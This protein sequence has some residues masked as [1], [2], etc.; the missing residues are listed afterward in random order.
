[1]IK[2]IKFSVILISI[3]TIF[4]CGDDDSNNQETQNIY[5]GCCSTEPVFGANVDN[6]DQSAGEIEVF[7]IVTQNED[8]IND[9]FSIRN[10]ELY[11]NHIVTIYNSVDE[12]IYEST[13]YTD[14][15]AMF[16]GYPQGENGSASI[17]S[18]GTYR[19]KIVIENEET[20]RKSGSF[21]VYTFPDPQPNFEGCNLGS[22]FDPV[23]ANPPN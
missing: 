10:I 19:Y 5:E 4:S 2:Q 23:I 22:Q 12:Q 6:L 7:T 21:C 13:N 17:I 8:G 3:F 16:P 20:F 14:F 11:S 9:M 1:M 15:E 18:N